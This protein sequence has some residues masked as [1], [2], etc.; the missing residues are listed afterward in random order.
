[1][2]HLD[3][4]ELVPEI[5]VSR[6]H[7]LDNTNRI[8]HLVAN[9]TKQQVS[10]VHQKHYTLAGKEE[11]PHQYNTLGIREVEERSRGRSG[12]GGQENFLESLSR[13]SWPPAASRAEEVGS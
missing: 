3:N 6:D 10:L 5:K 9:R 12:S 11:A 13:R 4:S 1:M 8:D 7:S 2:H